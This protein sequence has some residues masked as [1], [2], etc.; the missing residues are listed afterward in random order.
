[1][2]GRW[3]LIESLLVDICFSENAGR[4]LSYTTKKDS[5]RNTYM[6]L[7]TSIG[8]FSADKCFHRMSKPSFVKD[9]V[10]ELRI[11]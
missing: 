11:L 9:V 8:E 4:R 5:L 2:V 1:M 3:V 6:L 7:H 10:A